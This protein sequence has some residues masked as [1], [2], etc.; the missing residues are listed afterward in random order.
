M[1]NQMVNN[2]LQI[3]FEPASLK[4]ILLYNGILMMK[5]A[6]EG[7]KILE[8]YIQQRLFRASEFWKNHDFLKIYPLCA[9]LGEVITLLNPTSLTMPHMRLSPFSFR[10]EHVSTILQK[11]E[12]SFADEISAFYYMNLQ[13]NFP[14]STDESPNHSSKESLSLI[15]E[16][17]NEEPSIREWLSK[18]KDDLVTLQEEILQNT[19]D[20]LLVNYW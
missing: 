10:A 2:K 5:F 14:V 16:Q 1:A 15:L 13:N 12:E 19:I 3:G 17:D 6:I 4:T 8:K 18:W 9:K 7:W 11:M 20:G